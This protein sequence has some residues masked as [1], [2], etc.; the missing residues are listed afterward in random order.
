MLGESGLIGLALLL[1]PLVAM[2]VGVARALRRRPPPP[3]ARDLGIAGAVGV[4]VAAD[5][6]G[7]W[8]WQMP[9]V[10]LP[11]IV[12]GAAAL[13]A[14]VV[15]CGDAV[16]LPSWSGW[17]LAAVAVGRPARGGRADGGRPPRADGPRPRGRGEA[18]GGAVGG[19][20]R[21]RP[22][23][24]E[25]RHRDLRANIL[26]DLGR[27]RE[28]DAAFADAVAR[29]PRDWTIRADWAS[30][31]LRRGDRR[32]ARLLVVSAEPLNPLD[33]RI[34]GLRQALSE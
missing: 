4:A 5:M 2:G 34:A 15:E 7:D 11:A 17:P 33:E 3:L 10:V 13:K 1:V 21:R 18:P 30:A 12:L 24:A 28:A 25:P 19:R 26:D 22:R 32:A 8:G 27:D 23:P 16:R 9:G 6:M 20:R 14:A 29:S 31:L